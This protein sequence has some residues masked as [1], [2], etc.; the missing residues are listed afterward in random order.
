[1]EAS[2]PKARGLKQELNNEDSDPD[3]NTGPEEQQKGA[4]ACP[5]SQLIPELICQAAVGS[6]C[7]MWSDSLTE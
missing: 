6:V 4:G 1:M 2:F 7:L 5:E 3:L